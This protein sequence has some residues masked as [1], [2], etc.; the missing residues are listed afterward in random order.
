MNPI[1][2]QH[3]HGHSVGGSVL[4]PF[5]NHVS[6][7]SATSSN[8]QQMFSSSSAQVAGLGNHLGNSSNSGV[9]TSV[10]MECESPRLTGPSSI[11]APNNTSAS[12]Y[13]HSS[14]RPHN[15]NS[16][17]NSLPPTLSHAHHPHLHG[18]SL[19]S[20]SSSSSSSS[21]LPTQPHQMS[22]SLIMD[23]SSGGGSAVHA[24]NSRLGYSSNGPES[25][26]FTSLA[27]SSSS[28]VGS[29]VVASNNF[30]FINLNGPHPSSLDCTQTGSLNMPL[31]G[32][33][34]AFSNMN[35]NLSGTNHILNLGSN[36]VGGVMSGNPS[37]A[38][39]TVITTSGLGSGGAGVGSQA[40]GGSSSFP[41]PP[42]QFLGSLQNPHH[43]AVLPSY[44]AMT[45]SSSGGGGGSSAGIL[46][47]SESGSS[48]CSSDLGLRDHEGGAKGGGNLLM[49]L[50]SRRQAAVHNSSEDDRDE[51]P[52]VCGHQSPLSS[53]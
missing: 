14:S 32:A 18:R 34:A 19:I 25:L 15:P 5:L 38:P 35:L 40:G 47:G 33:P 42:V 22:S 27:T 24:L 16:A 36:L 6:S 50:S 21:R 45:S 51:S 23:S 49:S 43:S 37:S 7:G 13:L 1:I 28:A 2:H 8:V 26:D 11:V 10:D 39:S 20:G 41:L 46:G 17:N 53:H 12:S 3:G 48:A 44:G 9:L 29:S 31:P 4:N 30:P 52:M